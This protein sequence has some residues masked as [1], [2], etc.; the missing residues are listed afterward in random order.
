ML[1]AKS[2]PD[3]DEPYDTYMT[4]RTYPF[5]SAYQIA[6]EGESFKKMGGR[7]RVNSGDPG[8]TGVVIGKAAV[9]DR[10]SVV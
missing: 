2:I 10:K 1:Y 8:G 4:L 3:P 9:E 5:S 6:C 7:V